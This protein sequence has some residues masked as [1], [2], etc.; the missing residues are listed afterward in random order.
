MLGQLWR[1][2]AARLKGGVL[3][4][5]GT[6]S[7]PLFLEAPLGARYYSVS[8]QPDVAHSGAPEVSTDSRPARNVGQ[9]TPDSH[10]SSLRTH[11]LTPG[12]SKREYEER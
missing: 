7:L 3:T 1:Q 10:P 9:P 4:L 12:I 11:E 5:H 6:Y 2:N 8:G